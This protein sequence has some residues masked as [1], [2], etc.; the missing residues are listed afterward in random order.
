MYVIHMVATNAALRLHTCLNLFPICSCSS[1]SADSAGVQRVKT[2]LE[3]NFAQTGDVGEKKSG[4]NVLQFYEDGLGAK[5]SCKKISCYTVS[6]LKQ[7]IQ[8]IIV[9]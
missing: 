3:Y 4:K 5:F 7:N 1:L 6:S 9:T 8:L 2:T